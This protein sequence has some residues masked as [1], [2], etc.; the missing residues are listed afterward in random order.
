VELGVFLEVDAPSAGQD[1]GVLDGEHMRRFLADQRHRERDGLPSLGIKRPDGK[2]SIVT[3]TTTRSVVFN[4]LHK[5]LR[6]ALDTGVAER[7]GLARQFIVTVPTA[8]TADGRRPGG[9]VGVP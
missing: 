4:A 9:G 6:E 1:P 5:M 8:G 7:I 2:A 3:T